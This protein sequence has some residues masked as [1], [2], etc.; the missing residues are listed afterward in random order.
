[1]T[2]KPTLMEHT[3]SSLNSDLASIPWVIW[4]NPIFFWTLMFFLQEQP[5]P[6]KTTANKIVLILIEY[7]STVT[8]WRWC[9]HLPWYDKVMCLGISMNIWPRSS[10]GNRA[11]GTW[12][13]QQVIVTYGLYIVPRSCHLKT[14]STNQN[15]WPGNYQVHLSSNEEWIL[16]KNGEM[17]VR[18][19]QLQSNSTLHQIWLYYCY[20]III[21]FKI[22]TIRVAPKIA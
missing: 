13:V 19:K 6:I 5:D 10:S 21:W 2:D 20:N 16:K 3:I 15:K 12:K 8:H 11:R 17:H 22:I 18:D 14:Y 9:L 7:N 1:M 4:R